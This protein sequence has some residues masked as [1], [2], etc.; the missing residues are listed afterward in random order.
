V[1]EWLCSVYV[2][3]CV[4]A[5]VYV[6]VSVCVCSSVRLSASLRARARALVC[7]F[8][9]FFDIALSCL[10]GLARHAFSAGRGRL[11]GGATERFSGTQTQ[12]GR[13]GRRGGGTLTCSA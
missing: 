10:L 3:T 11:E 13:E 2:C 12:G 9:R 5:S 7:P 6:R 8:S 1:C 4:C